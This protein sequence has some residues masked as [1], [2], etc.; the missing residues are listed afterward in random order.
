M[1]KPPGKRSP[2]PNPIGN[3]NSPRR[4]SMGKP[5]EKEP[6]SNLKKKTEASGS[7]EQ[8]KPEKCGTC[9]KTCKEDD[10]AL[11]CEL[12]DTWYHTS[13][14]KISDDEYKMLKKDT[15]RKCPLFHY[16]CSKQCN[17]TAEKLLSGLTKV[18]QQMEQLQ[19]QMNTVD[20]KIDSIEKGK[21]TEEMIK[22]VQKITLE[23]QDQTDKKTG[24]DEVRKAID[25]NSKIQREEI[26]DR[27][28]R[29]AN[30][31]MFRVPEVDDQPAQERQKKDKTTVE[32]LLQDIETV[33]KPVDIRRLGNIKKDQEN[34]KNPR[35]IRMT[36]QSELARD[37]A[38]SAVHRAKKQDKGVNELCT[39]IS[40]RKDLTP[41][42][43]Q[44]LYKELMKKREESQQSGDVHAHWVRARGRIKNIGKYPTEEEK[45]EED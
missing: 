2:G 40:V 4:G 12:C 26:E 37:E 43:E 29:K 22:T 15:G 23:A 45:K 17:K 5:K 41:L 44:E 21:F 38:L 18:E 42:E 31:V 11:Q 27:V 19:D 35:P 9:D 8:T 28:R 3:A 34:D 39:K 14:E 16:Y 10:K 6:Q 7:G 30:L 25:E 1:T 33:H 13:C 20:Q 36:F 32:K 24:T